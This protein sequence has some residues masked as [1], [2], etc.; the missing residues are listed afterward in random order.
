MQQRR[1]RRTRLVAS[2]VAIASSAAL[3]GALT[4]TAP[5]SATTTRIAYAPAATAAIHPGVQ[6]YTEGAQCTANFVFSDASGATYV[7]YAAHCAGTGAA[8]DTERLRRRVPAPRHRGRLRRGRVVGLRGHP[9]RRRHARLLV[10]ADDAG[11]RRERRRHLC[12]QRPRPGRGGPGRR[13]PGQP[14]RCPS[15]AA[16]SASTPT[17]PWPV[18][19]STRYG[20]S[21]LRAGVTALS[22]KQGTEPRHRGRRLVAPGLHRQPGRSRRLRERVPRRGR[23]RPRRAVHAGPRAARRLERCRG[24]RARARL[25]PARRAASP[26]SAWCPARRR[27]RRSCDSSPPGPPGPVSG[28]GGSASGRAR[29]GPW[30]IRRPPS[31]RD[32]RRSWPSSAA[33]CWSPCW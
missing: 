27:S 18:T 23:P 12:V 14:A 15:G 24:P 19:P 3:G 33:R 9:G 16:R 20:N 10:L 1:T 25:R 8:T 26:V 5:A 6:M 31:G 17:G 7:G 13:R 30:R 4:S 28:P 2:L 21:S 22:P 32:G 29:F 11:A